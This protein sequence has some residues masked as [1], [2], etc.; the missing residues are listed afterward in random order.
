M[1][2]LLNYINIFSEFG[3]TYHF[4]PSI[5]SREVNLTKSAS[6]LQFYYLD[7]EIFCRNIKYF[8]FKCM[9]LGPWDDTNIMCGPT[10]TMLSDSSS[11]QIFC[12]II[13]NI[14]D[15]RSHTCQPRDAFDFWWQRP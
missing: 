11:E 9:A 2:Y 4:N 10:G 6:T 5:A 1:P 15:K 8:Y 12:R 13:N 7:L 14:F 3:F